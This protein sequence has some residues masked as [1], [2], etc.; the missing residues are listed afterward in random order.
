MSFRAE[1]KTF[2]KAR[3]NEQYGTTL[4]GILLILAPA[5]F[6]GM[7]ASGI[8][9]IFHLA[10]QFYSPMY[11]YSYTPIWSPFI[12]SG[13]SF[14]ISLGALFLLPFTDAG[15]ASLT[16]SVARRQK[17]SAVQPYVEGAKNYTRK[18]GGLLWM[19]LFVFL[20]SLLFIIPGIVK[21]YSYRFTPYILADC[22]NVKA[23]DALKL[24]MRMTDGVKGEIFVFDLSFIGWFLLTFLTCGIL[25]IYTIPY[26][27][28]AE[29]TL[30]ESMK[31]SALASGRIHE[32]D[33]S[34]TPD[35]YPFASYRTY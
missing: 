34:P 10:F 27:K 1:V 13:I 30:Y 23:K 32:N 18:L 6:L 26:F 19:S 12:T 15:C 22:P 21:A 29:A 33:L 28:V 9:M 3:L 17:A 11:T 8:S 4:A 31:N 16:L 7:V 35:F 5:F 20:W 14:M 24:S 25:S 2:A